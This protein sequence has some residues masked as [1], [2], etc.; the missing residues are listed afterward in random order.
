[1]SESDNKQDI[2]DESNEVKSQWIKW[3]KVKD[4]I[5]GTLV[6]I[7]EMESQLPDQVGKM[8]KLYE[9]RANSGSFHELDDKKQ[10]VA[11]ATVL[12]KGDIWTIGGKIGIDAQM[13]NAKIGQTIGMRFVEEKPSKTKG[14]NP[15]KVIKVFLGGMD[16]D[17]HGQLP[18]DELPA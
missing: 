15:S 18:E 14:F 5:E 10:P 8:V 2:F 16:P 4:F 1:M 11:E 6:D 17:F 7:R 12:E 3:G 13:R 9:I